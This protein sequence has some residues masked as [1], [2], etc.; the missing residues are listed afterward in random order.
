M[1]RFAVPTLLAFAVA[2]AITCSKA[3]APGTALPATVAAVPGAVGLFAEPLAARTKADGP[4]F[5]KVDPGRSGLRFQNE[6][7]RENSVAYVYTGAGLAVGDYDGDGWPDVYLVS[8]DGPNKLFRQTAPLVFEDV[9]A[10][11]GGLDGGDAWGNAASF[12]DVDDDG[13]LDL[14]VCNLE[15]PNLLYLNQ[16][17][18]TFVEKAGPFG[19]GLV[20]ASMGCAF[21]DYDNDGDL[22]LYVLT[23]RMLKNLLP[24]EIIAGVRLPKAIKK[25]KAELLPPYPTFPKDANGNLVVPPGYED[26]FFTVPGSPSPFLA[27][28]CDRLFRNDGYGHWVDVTKQSGIHDQGNGLSVVWWD[29]DGD[30]LMDLYV[31]NDF[32]SPDQLY[33]NLG[34]GRFADVTKERLPHTAFFGMGCDFGDL[35][36]DGRF[37]L[38]VADMSSTQHYWG[39]MLMGS[40]DQHRWFLMNAVPQQYMRNALY[41]N[42]GTERFLEAAYLAGLASSDWTWAVRFADLDDDG[43]LDF[44]ATNGIPVFT[45]NPDIG[46]RFTKLWLEGARQQAVEL[47]RSIPSV[48][49]KN[50]ARRNDGAAVG[51]LHFTDVGAEWGLDESNVAHGAVVVDLDRDG[52]LDVLTNNLNAPC[53]LFENRGSDGHRVL[54]E[55]RGDESN[56]RGVGAVVEVTAGGTK[57]T[58]QVSL[59]RGYMSAGDAVLHFGLGAA[60][61]IDALEVRWPSGLVN[62]FE[63]LAVD[64]RYM[65]TE[66]GA[67]L[68]DEVG[69]VIRDPLVEAN[70]DRLLSAERLAARHRERDF[71]DYAVQPLLPH[72]LSRLGPGAAIGDVDGDGRDEYWIG[73]AAGQAGSLMR[74]GGKEHV[75]I[76]GPWSDDAGCEDLGAC[77]LDFDRDGDLDL[78]VA[79]GSVEAGER[80][81]LLRDRLYVNDGKGA[82]TKAP[83]GVLPDHRDS[84]SCVSAADFDRD[85]DLDLFVGTRVVPGRFPQSGPSRLLRND[86][87]RFVD[88]AAD[89]APGLREAGMVTSALWTDVDGD[90]FVDLVVAASWQTLRVF[91]NERG[92][93]LVDRTQA[94]GLHELRGQWNG[95]A[96]GDLDGDGDVDL[97]AT[98]LG[99][100]TKYKASLQ[101]PQ[102]LYAR[103]FDGNGTFDVVESKTA[104]EGELPVRGLSCSS[105]AMP[106]V[107]ERFPTYDQFARAKLGDIYG[108]ALGDS[109]V[110]E[111]NELRHV[112]LEQRDGRFHPSPLPW[113][114]QVSTAFGVAITDADADGVQDLVLVHN[115][116]SPEPETGRIDGG[117]GLLLRGLGKLQFEPVRGEVSGL[118]VTGDAKALALL[119]GGGTAGLLITRNDAEALLLHSIRGRNASDGSSSFLSVRLRGP[120]GNPTG[121][122]ARI[123][124]LQDGKVLAR[125]EVQAG[126]SYLAQSSPSV[127][128]TKVPADAVVRVHWPDGSSSETKVANPSGAMVV[129]R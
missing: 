72:R 53:S 71:D 79:S 96:A 29:F 99:L 50:V 94:L 119:D 73:G 51:G 31:A 15:S 126:G 128:F 122:G 36:H 102:R 91:G 5:H 55:L 45:D 112:V 48:A 78:Y 109:L 86:G 101:K 65:V 116:F 8:Q 90:G 43:W 68:P 52:D 20:A 41:V 123:E 25:T 54:V 97:V 59:T 56:S 14:Y 18:G 19:L 129:T 6:L 98:N 125:G 120:V 67:S 124:L 21:A 127:A 69:Q 88:V 37:D 113:L 13:D 34:N 117:L 60:T 70:Q 75:A 83:D 121:V 114:A 46:E 27:G 87:G 42:T 38:C 17:N 4:R 9:T 57:Q 63:K 104:A 74:I 118:L 49:E 110:L 47:F 30:G 100:N 24:D 115:F 85:G 82:F 7:R 22:D 105:Q 106:F 58:A 10:K 12:A 16:G 1:L 23:N 81:E 39:K 62:R 3:P 107:R 95:L 26:H 93:R 103:D 28:Q 89:L 76:A 111:C 92:E 11:A 32:Q 35:D 108:K 44:Y 40:M 61:T 80:T 84:S 2:V 77:F 33:R 66:A 64:Q